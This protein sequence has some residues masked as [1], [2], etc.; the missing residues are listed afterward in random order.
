MQNRKP[1]I[2]VIGSF[3]VDLMSKSP[4]LPKPG[5]TVMGG[6]FHMGAGG[7]GS[8]Q[9]IAAAKLGAEVGI[10]AALG[11]DEFGDMAYN[12]LVEAGVGTDGVK[13]VEGVSTGIA[14]IIVDDGSGENMIVVAPGSNDFLNKDDVKQ[15]KERIAEADYV[16]MQLEI[17][18][19][20]VE[21]AA[22]LA[23]EAN[24]PVILDPAPGRPLP[25]ELLANVDVL[26]PNEDEAQ[27]ITG[28]EIAD[29][30]SAEQAA[31]HLLAR[32]P[33]AVVITLG[34]LGALAVTKDE[35][36][37][38]PAFAVDAVDTTGAGDAFNGALAVALGEKLP[39]AEA[40]RF[41][42]A[43]AALS[44]TKVGTSIAAPCRSDVEKFLKQVR[45]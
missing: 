43:A 36:V 32:G 13:R 25:D 12:A 10:V 45:K 40:C 2:C 29:L 3:V 33:R 34:G 9:A 11:R 42:A 6:P 41:A 4:H 23:Q 44:V 15:A 16:V 19:E 35:T 21:Y 26:T 24:T 30:A 38:I 28:I 17:P 7:K 39:L 20:T 14:L 27:I 18:L 1:I 37:H 31:K 8:N 22:R 5:Q